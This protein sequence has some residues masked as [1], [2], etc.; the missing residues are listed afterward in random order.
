MSDPLQ[1]LNNKIT[2]GK[3]SDFKSL[4]CVSL[5][6]HNNNN[7]VLKSLVINDDEE[8]VVNDNRLTSSYLTESSTLPAGSIYTSL[9]QE[10]THSK[11]I[12]ILLEVD[13]HINQADITILVSNDDSN[14]YELNSHYVTEH[15]QGLSN[16]IVISDFRF[17]HYKIQVE[18]TSGSD[19]FVFS[20]SISF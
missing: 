14:F 3:K 17:K 1:Q 16:Q 12:S 13:A 19:S 6:A 20:L 9:S 15:V 8:L 10:L 5:Y 7:D 18:N 4:Q 2:K 11:D